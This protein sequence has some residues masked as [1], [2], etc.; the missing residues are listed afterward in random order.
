MIETNLFG[1]VHGARAA[2]PYF[3]EQGS[4]VLIN[5][6][7]IAGKIGLPYISSAYVASKF[8]VVGLSEC[9]RQE[10]LDA[11]DIHVCTILPASIDTPLFQQAGNCTGRAVKPLMPIY[12]A[13]Q[14]ARAIVLAARWPRR[15]IV[16]GGAGRRMLAMHSLSPAFAERRAAHKMER[17]HFQDQAAEPGP[18]NLFDPTSQQ[19]AISGGWQESTRMPAVLVAAAIV[20]SAALGFCLSLWWQS[21]RGLASVPRRP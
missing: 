2:I 12:H 9:L 16:V 19:T 8:A 11:E 5:V 1:Y 10:L 14:V 3:R 7:S 17:D 13:R 20:G 21:H 15:E 18:G 6:A 4:G